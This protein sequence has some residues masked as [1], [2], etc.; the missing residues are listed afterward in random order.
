MIEDVW[1]FFISTAKENPDSAGY[2]HKVDRKT[3]LPTRHFSLEKYLRHSRFEKEFIHFMDLKRD[4]INAILSR[5]I[6]EK[7]PSIL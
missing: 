6:N 5:C 4:E 3:G 2:I 1:G 7:V